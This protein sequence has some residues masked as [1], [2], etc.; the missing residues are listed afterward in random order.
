MAVED[1]ATR[2]AFRRNVIMAF[3]VIAAFFTWLA[4]GL[5]GTWA[6]TAVDD[7]GELV[8]ALL[9]ARA[10]L[11]RAGRET[12]RIRRGW[13]LLGLSALVW[14]LGEAVWS[15]YE[16]VEGREVPF[17][18]LADI[19]F[20]AAVPLALAAVLTFFSPPAGWTS[21]VRLIVDGLI[22]GVAVLYVSWV[23]VLGPM[24]HDLSGGLLA[25]VVGL[26]YPV[27][28]VIIISAVILVGARSRTADDLPFG[29]IAAGLVALAV[30]DSAFAYLALQG[31][32]GTG[33]FIDTGWLAGYLFIALAAAKPAG[34]GRGERRTGE[35]T[36]VSY[37]PV[38]IVLAVSA[39]QLVFGS[40]PAGFVMYLGGT[41][42]ALVVIRQ[43][44]TLRENH[45]LTSGLEAMVEAR[46]RQLHDSEE[47]FRSMIQTVSDVISIV[48]RDGTIRFVS[49]SVHAAFGYR[50]EELIGQTV[51]GF[52]H[53]EDTPTVSAFLESEGETNRRITARFRHRQ[54]GWRYVE[55]VGSDMTQNG[56]LGGFVFAS[57]DM[58]E[59]REL[60]EQLSHQAFHDPLTGLANR[61]LLADRIGHALARISR[62]GRDLAVLFVDLDDFKSVNDTLGHAPGDA[63]LLEV[64]RRITSCVRPGDTVA[65]LG[66]DEFAVLMEE[67]DEPLAVAV[68]E[69]LQAALHTPFPLGD[70]EICV[71]ASVGIARSGADTVSEAEL[72]RN[73]DVAMYQAKDSGKARYTVFRPE[74]HEAVVRRVAL[75]GELRTAVDER[76]FELHYQPLV[77]LTDRH[78]VGFEALVRWRH[79]VR[80]MVS[81]LEFIPLAEET[82]LIIPLGRWILE[83]ATAQLAAWDLLPRT[84]PPL[85]MSIN[86]SAR[87]LQSRDLVTTLADVLAR[88]GVAPGR[89]TLELTESMLLEDV[90]GTIAR[91]EELKEIG[92]RLAIDDFGTGFSSLSYLRRFPV[93]TLKVDK[94]F[95]DDMNSARGSELTRALLELGAVLGLKT[96]A[97]GI[98]DVGQATQLEAHG[99]DF[100]QGY[101]FSRPIPPA[102]VEALLLAGPV[103]SPA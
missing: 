60:E 90:T 1:L 22:V 4:T 29:W 20:L 49:P 82:G 36:L 47:R 101:M 3:V 8:V 81:P 72:L 86:V 50:P 46:T 98:E 12:A 71:T 24:V 2:S 43:V 63:L 62:T 99:C 28:D 68:A 30:A 48:D 88:S 45:T 25:Q 54:G 87:Q 21:R 6:T 59:R 14:G 33:N 44:F 65:R 77:A 100:G 16:L 55:A 27:G 84:G 34:H 11:R 69:R 78:I 23:V 85:T 76:Q 79:P 67:A 64:S 51:Y 35:F 15:Y 70:A 26:A 18:S 9:A 74:M 13:R 56:A 93:D 89:I 102:Q 37:V 103:P 39:W 66:G 73:A 58:T 42:F 19:G 40:P 94:S 31:D 53:H 80:G 57:R 32:Y 38:S 95:V 7:L 92:V 5:F 75:L 83:E 52:L 97:E 96:V 17:P 61:A 10:C 41:L 91:L